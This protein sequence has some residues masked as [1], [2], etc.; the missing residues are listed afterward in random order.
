MTHHLSVPV[1]RH[2]VFK[3]SY[4]CIAAV[5]A[6]F[7]SL[8]APVRDTELI[9]VGDRI[10]T[11][12]VLANRMARR[13]TI[14]VPA[15]AADLISTPTPH[16]ESK[17]EGEQKGE[18]PAA[19]S[20]RRRTRNVKQRVGPFSIWTSGVWEKES[21]G[22]RA[23]EKGLLSTIQR[24]IVPDASVHTPADLEHFVVQPTPPVPAISKPGAGDGVLRRAWTY[25]RR[26]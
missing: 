16:P 17:S 8:K 11:D 19:E 24:Y 14:P 15:A 13:I 20:S 4:S 12:V 18:S 21:M 1:L 23:L 25:V 26:R 7:S 2:N 5:R 22:M 10:F 9:V 3:P 6:Y